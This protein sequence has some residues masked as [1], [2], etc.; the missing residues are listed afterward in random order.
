MI[1]GVVTY[2]LPE[3]TATSWR[4]GDRT[5]VRYGGEL[6]LTNEG[7]AKAELEI[8]LDRGGR[9]LVLDLRDLTFLDARGVHVLL[10]ALSACEAL[11][12]QLHVI[13]A[14]LRVQR[15]LGLCGLAKRFEPMAPGEPSEQL[16][17]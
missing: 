5:T 6:D 9:E 2:L 14:P 8:A 3:F 1:R 16:A 4:D 17:A 15:I 13:P 12:R 10:E 7:L 11:Q